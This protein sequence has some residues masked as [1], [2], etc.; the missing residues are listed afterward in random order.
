MKKFFTI[1]SIVLLGAVACTKETDRL[2]E[3]PMQDDGPKVAVTMSVRLPVELMANTRSNTV[4]TDANKRGEQPIIE[5]IRV[6][7]FGTSGY[8]QAYEL[9]QPMDRIEEGGNV[10]YEPTDH[11]ATTN[12][13]L[14]YFK[15]L[16][17]VYEGEAHV[18][19]VANGPETIRWADED[20]FSIMSQMYTTDN[21][22][23]Y[24]ARVVLEDGILA[25]LSDDGIMVTDEDGNYVPSNEHPE[26]HLDACQRSHV[27]FFRSHGGWFVRRRL[28]GLC[29]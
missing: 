13:E 27:R 14:Y 12:N 26:C 28:Q 7:V 4:G 11:Y 5:S 15:V 2:L 16:L 29:L 22:G 24:W 9:A 1:L 23:G 10:H 20:E 6:A 17:P 25:D 8:T 18:H 21:V 19:I 3:N